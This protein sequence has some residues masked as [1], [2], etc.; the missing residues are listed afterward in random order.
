MDALV[1]NSSFVLFENSV[2]ILFVLFAGKVLSAGEKSVSGSDRSD[3]SRWR[4][5]NARDRE[6]FVHV[7]AEVNIAEEALWISRLVL[8]GEGL[9]LIV[10]QREVHGGED[11]FELHTGNAALSELVKV[12]EELLNTDALH[13]NCS[14]EAILNI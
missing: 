14:L 12:A 3:S 10:G 1:F 2:D 11:R 9:E 4:L 13:D 5:I 6:G 7:S 8:L